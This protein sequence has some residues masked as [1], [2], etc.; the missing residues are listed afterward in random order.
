MA[1]P[2]AGRAERIALA[3]GEVGQRLVTAWRSHLRVVELMAADQRALRSQ[4]A[5][6]AQP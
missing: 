2:V 3:V 5:V 6:G 4:R 1:A